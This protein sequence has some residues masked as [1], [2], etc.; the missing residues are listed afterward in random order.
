[1]G[2]RGPLYINGLVAELL[3]FGFS[4]FPAAPSLILAF[5]LSGSSE[6]GVSNITFP[7]LQNIFNI[8]Q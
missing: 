5:Y 6:F 4:F 8:P 2:G 3:D 1:M 7:V